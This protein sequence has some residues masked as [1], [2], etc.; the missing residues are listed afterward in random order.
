MATAEGGGV[1]PFPAV[2][3]D[4][5][6]PTL[7][8]CIGMLLMNASYCNFAV[9]HVRLAAVDLSAAELARVRCR[10][11]LGRFDADLLADLRTDEAVLRRLETLAAF[12]DSGR[13]EV[14]AAR[15]VCW[16]PDFSVHHRPGDPEFSA[17]GLLGSH[18][19]GQLPGANG[20]RIASII[21]G[22]VVIRMARHFRTL[23][24]HGHDVRAVIR[25]EL[26]A[27]VG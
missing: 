4:H 8:E 25:N 13:L 14:R 15:A 22:E 20:P 17:V 3:D 12:I 1:R 6:V 16:Y 26:R 2:L 11:L 19:L 9:Q 10:L 5:T 27:R 18:Q 24:R 7:R 21:Y 23:W